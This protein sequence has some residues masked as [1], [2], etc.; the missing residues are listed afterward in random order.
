MA[1]CKSVPLAILG[2]DILFVQSTLTGYETVNSIIIK[3]DVKR[4]AQNQNSVYL[5]ILIKLINMCF[6]M[7]DHVRPYW[8]SLILL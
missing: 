4:F 1:G 5:S 3:K 7:A 2:T 8:E 6:Y